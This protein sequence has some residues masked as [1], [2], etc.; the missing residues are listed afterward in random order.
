MTI[1][2]TKKSSK[3][4]GA[5]CKVMEENKICWKIKYDIL[6]FIGVG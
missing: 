4:S 5:G 2:Q 1:F 3:L 6:F